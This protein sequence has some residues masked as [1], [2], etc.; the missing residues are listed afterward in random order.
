MKTSFRKRSTLLVGTLALLASGM[1]RVDAESNWPRWRGASADGHSQEKGLPHT[2]TEDSIVWKTP[3][4]GKG[5][6]SPTIWGNRIF[7]TSALEQGRQ[8][9]VMCIDR[10]DGTIEWE[11]IAWTGEPEPSHGMNGWASATCATDGQRVYAFF[12]RGGGLH[13]YTVDG[14]HVWS[15]DLG[16]FE[17]PWG[18]AASPLL[19]GDLVIQNCDSDVNAYLIALDKKTG[20]EVWKTQRPEHRGWSSPILIQAGDHDEIVLNGHAGV[21]AYAPETGE[22]LWICRCKQGRGSP[23]VTLA[24]S[25]LFVA[26]G[27]SGGGAYCVEPGGTGDVTESK[28]KWITRRGGRDLPSPIIVGDVLLVVGLRG[29]ILTGYDVRDGK[30]LW[31]T[32]LGGQLSSSPVC[33]D[34]VAF[35]IKESGETVVVDPN[36]EDEDKVVGTNSLGTPA[37]DELFR[38]SITPCDGKLFMRSDQN[39]YCIGSK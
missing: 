22:E 37:D 10:R 6:S 25:L 5:H 17:G 2:W 19:V 7:L 34:G 28:R 26:N 21:M 24:N 35:F 16:Q 39:L 8:R 30:E 31:V 20:N 29:A 38:A 1:G 14:I 4:N 9:M 13:C 15:R 3:L 23:T 11:Q 12:G 27:L 32:R 18:T 33:F 36:S